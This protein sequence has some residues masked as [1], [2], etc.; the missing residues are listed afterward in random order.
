VK[1]ASVR[2]SKES[3]DNADDGKSV[4]SASVRESKESLDNADDGKSVKSATVRESKEGFASPPD[5]SDNVLQQSRNQD[6]HSMK[7]N[8]ENEEERKEEEQV[9]ESETKEEDDADE[10]EYEEDYDDDYD[11]EEEEEV[12][13]EAAQDD[14]EE[15]DENTWKVL[16]VLGE[17]N[18]G[19]V[20]EVERRG[21]R[22]AMKVFKQ[23]DDDDEETAAYAAK[24]RVREC[25][26]AKLLVHENIVK[27]LDSAE[28]PMPY[29]VFE[30]MP[31]NLLEFIEQYPNGVAPETVK[32]MSRQ[33]CSS[34]AY[35]HH[36]SV[37][38]RD[39][40]PENVLVQGF[41]NDQGV[42][43]LCDF[44]AARRLD[45]YTAA[46]RNQLEELDDMTNYVGSRWYRA[47]ES[48]CFFS[49]LCSS[50][51]PFNECFPPPQL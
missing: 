22:A 13:K 1:S 41:Q 32:N 26:L 27:L 5:D 44:G 48:K 45:V 42:L 14:G 10:E 50:C 19:T 43:K 23:D 15:V 29:L 11:D 35:C 18:Y 2:E 46:S 12:G 4:K 47:P 20:S 17:G 33:L 31:M 39:L 7:G 36:M 40:K 9:V 37:V 8:S 21:V 34:L 24:T 51:P 6:L 30:L 49:L 25:E 3:L 16:R 28:K 38:H